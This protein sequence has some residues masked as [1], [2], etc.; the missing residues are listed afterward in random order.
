M[1]IVDDFLEWKPDKD[2]NTIITNPPFKYALEYIKKAL[3]INRYGI[4]IFLLRLNFLESRKRYPFWKENMPS[5]VLVMA[6]RPKF[7][8]GKTDSIAYAWFIWEPTEKDT[9]LKVISKEELV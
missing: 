5:K 3:D 2:Y 9:I 1:D 6:E 8:L 4:N 7:Y